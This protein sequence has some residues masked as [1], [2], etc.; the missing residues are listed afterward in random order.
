MNGGAWCTCAA[1]LILPLDFSVDV[2]YLSGLG[3]VLKQQ[4]RVAAQRQYVHDAFFGPG[5]NPF[6]LVGP[7][8]ILERSH[9]RKGVND[10]APSSTAFP[11]SP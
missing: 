9:G 7:E 11:P 5:H 4:N 1:K 8:L 10:S 2:I 6:H 3:R